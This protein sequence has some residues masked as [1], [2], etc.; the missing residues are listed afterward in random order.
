MSHHAYNLSTGFIDELWQRMNGLMEPTEPSEFIG[1]IFRDIKVIPTP[2]QLAAIMD[3]AF[4]TSFSRDEGNAVTVSVIFNRAEKSFDTFLFDQPIAFDVKTLVKLGAALENPRADIG[5]W[6][7]SDG[8]LKI[9][10]FKTRSEDVIIAN[11]WVQA[12][13]PGKVLITFGGK[14][15]AALISN[16]AVFIDHANLMRAVIPK[17][18]LAKDQRTDK[19]LKMLRYNSLLT[20]ARAMRAHCRG[21]TLLVVP[22]SA[23]W[24]RSIDAPVPY[25]GGASFLES[26]YDVTLKPTLLAPITDFFAA[27]IKKKENSQLEKI[28]R[29]KTQIDQQCRHIARLTAVDGALAM[30]FDRFVFCFGAKIITAEGQHNPT[31]MRVVKPVEGDTGS[32][33]SLTD[34]GGT[35]HQSAAIFAHAQPG[36]VAIVVSQDGDVTFFTTDSETGELIAVQQ[37]ELAVLH[38]GLGAAF[39]SFSRVAEM[40]LI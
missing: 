4:W 17:L 8:D 24:R 34:I 5:V 1:D 20:T 16:Q 30:T 29:M 2:E 32:M 12:L 13:G 11:L 28:A 25:T 21:G 39:W 19:M 6:P 38:E 31:S 9:W 23:D 15:L 35:R 18:S 27:L 10:G 36:S 3:G 40:E 14:S 7:D 22:D 26:D 33:L 37:A